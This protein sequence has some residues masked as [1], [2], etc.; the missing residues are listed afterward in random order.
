M[1]DVVLC[2]DRKVLL[3]MAVAGRSALENSS[4]GL[5]FWIICFGYSESDKDDIRR[6]F[7]H[8]NLASVAFA[9]LEAHKV[10]GFRQTAV[11]GSTMSY[12]RFYIAELFPSLG[13]CVYLDSDLLVLRDLV[14]TTSIDLGDNG[15][16]A[17]LDIST[18]KGRS[19]LQTYRV[20]LGLSNAAE[21]VNTGFMII[22]LD[23]WRKNNITELVTQTSLDKADLL[24]T[25][26]Q[27]VLNLVF[28]GKT[29]FLSA[30]WNTS[31]YEKP[32][33]ISGKVVH[34][35]GP[36]KPWHARYSTKFKDSYYRDTISECFHDILD[37]TAFRGK[38]PWNPLYLGWMKEAVASRVPTRAMIG[39]KLRQLVG[40]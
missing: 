33:P 38:R 12:A 23:F 26:D 35:I 30:D 2:G 34:L 15:I 40:R 31:Q 8:K 37:R 27:D 39:R 13:R 16:A 10:S 11:I 36:Q 32:E 20:D 29:A 18:R 21:Y 22:D 14:E 9:D 17:A 7:Q 4:V 3:G 5:R 24:H 1:I 25:Q 28:E 19:H 6:S